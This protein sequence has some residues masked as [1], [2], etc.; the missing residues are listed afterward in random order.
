M[1]QPKPPT[2]TVYHINN[3]VIVPNAIPDTKITA[4]KQYQKR[5]SEETDGR[6]GGQEITEQDR[7]ESL[8]HNIRSCKVDWII[9]NSKFTQEITGMV[10]QQITSAAMDVYGFDTHRVE[11][12]QYTHYT[13]VEDNEVKD[14]YDWHT[15]SHMITKPVP[16][17]R[18]VSASIQLSDSDEYTGCNLEFPGLETFFQDAEKNDK[19]VAH[20]I[21][22]GEPID[23]EG[24]RQLMRQKGTGIFFP[25]VFSHRVTP[26]ESGER[27]AL[28]CWLQGPKFR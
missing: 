1:T 20:S 14:H 8:R 24:M 12:L 3:L 11:P 2:Q 16:F 6:V 5:F 7:K 15:D 28:V 21:Q 25:S 10:Q 4:L 19:P 18:K 27:F 23:A 26:I 22:T 13:Y 17:D 9:P